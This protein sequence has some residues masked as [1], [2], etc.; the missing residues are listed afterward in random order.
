MINDEQPSGMNLQGID[1]QVFA[2]LIG[3]THLFNFTKVV[4]E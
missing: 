1:Y 3:Q 2:N 4:Y